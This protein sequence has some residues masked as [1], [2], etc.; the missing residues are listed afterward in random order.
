[1]QHLSLELFSR[2]RGIPGEPHPY[3]GGG[4]A[5]N[6]L[7][8]GQVSF[9]MGNAD[10]AIPQVR[11]GALKALC[12]TGKERLAALPDL[13]AL[14]ET[15]PGFE[16][17]EWNGIFVPKG[18]SPNVILRLNRL[19]NDT[20]GKPAVA[21]RLP[22]M[23]LQ[24]RQNTPEQFAASSRNRPRAGGLHPRAIIRLE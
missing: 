2:P 22:Q 3:R 21:E 8:A 19:L 23:E 12:H 11:S 7:L 4:P 17:Y 24:A 6:D 18:T 1:M 15:L 10:T 13:P 14:S 20:W 16:T 9:Y 5:T